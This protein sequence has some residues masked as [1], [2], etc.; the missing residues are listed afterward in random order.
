MLFWLIVACG[1][2]LIFGSFGSVILSRRGDA[3][4]RKQASSILWGRSECPTCKHRLYPHDLIPLLSFLFQWGKCRYCHRKSDTRTRFSY[5]FW[6]TLLVFMVTRT[7]NTD[8]L[9]SKCLDPLA[10]T[11]IWCV[12]VRGAYSFGSCGN[13]KLLSWLACW[14]L[15]YENTLVRFSLSHVLFIA[16]WCSK[17][18]R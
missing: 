9:D 10:S 15:S 16:L 8:F 1:L 14:P 3:A 12:A 7:L 5:D 18:S 2:W 6:T 13:G 17:A 11:G 4:T